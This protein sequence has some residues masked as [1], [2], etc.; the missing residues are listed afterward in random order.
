VYLL[1]TN[2]CIAII[3]R[4]PQA[5][6]KFTRLLSEPSISSSDRFIALK[7]WDGAV[8]PEEQAEPVKIAIDYEFWQ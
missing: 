2:I 1:D 8:T 5:L 4:H 7:T 3:D 6:N